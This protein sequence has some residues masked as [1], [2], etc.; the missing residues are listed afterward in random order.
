MELI[1]PSTEYKDSF[2]EA[3]K[4]FQ[5]DNDYTNRNRR[6]RNLSIPKLENDFGSFVAEVGSHAEGKNLQ[7]GYEP[8]TE[9]WFVDNGEFIGRTSIRHRLND[10][11]TYIGG[12]IGY[13]IRPTKRGKGY[14]N[15]I[16][17]L[18]L[19]KGKELGLTRVLITSDAR[20]I[21]SRKIIEKN[22]GVFENKVVNHEKGFEG[23][24]ALRY[25]I[26]I[27]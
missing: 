19:R 14:G 22:G 7:E 13:D 18:A 10:K 24:D 12:H 1:E 16:F 17:E 3:V 11:L 15:K 21:A 26:D 27:K 2:I 25:W 23:F 5:A 4:E 9:Y 8:E 20:N 6:Y